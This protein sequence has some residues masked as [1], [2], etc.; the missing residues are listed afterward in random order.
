MVNMTDLEDVN[1]WLVV[2]Q[3]VDHDGTDKE[4]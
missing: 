2:L 3:M 1:Y 4:E